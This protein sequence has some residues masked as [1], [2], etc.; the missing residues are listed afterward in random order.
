M[1]LEIKQIV[2]AYEQKYNPGDT[3]QGRKVAHREVAKKI[4]SLV[5]AKKI[6]AMRFDFKGMYQKLVM[7]QDLEEG[8][9]SSSAF[10]NIASQ[11][12]SSVMIDGYNSFPKNGDK[13]VRVVPSKLKVS[14]VAGWTAI[15]AVKQVNES[16]PYDEVIPPD[17]KT[18]TIRNFKR[19]GLISLTKEALFF[20]QTGDLMDRAMQIGEEGA[21]SRDEIIMNVVSDVN[22]NALSNAALYSAGNSNLITSNA[23]GTP[24]WEEVDH[25]LTSK[26][27]EQNKPIWVFGD[28][29]IMVIAAN[30]KSVARKLQS[31]EHGPLGT[32]NLDVNLAQNQFDWIV[33]PY[34]AAAVTDWWYGAFK[35]QF[36]WEEVWPLETFSRVGQDTEEG[37]KKDVIQQ[38]KISY[39]GGAGAV[40]TRWVF[41]NNA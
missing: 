20:D 28:R 12:I 40:D 1:S 9:L 17:E 16:E 14:R 31:N 4:R 30:N 15:G 35:R 24:G 19:G 10:P 22:N 5:E 21:R 11:I 34:L 6:D 29:P 3:R 33:N 41:E 32:G 38:V 13:L 23:L 39:Y 36:R 37:F 2:E 18:Q 26:K 8:N 7:E 25:Q 27:D